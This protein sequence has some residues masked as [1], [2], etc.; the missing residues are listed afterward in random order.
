[1][2]GFIKNIIRI[3]KRSNVMSYIFE[4]IKVK[5]IE[6]KI[7]LKRTATSDGKNNLPRPNSETFSNCENEALIYADELRNIQISKAVNYLNSIKD[8]IINSTA[9]L[10]QKNFYIDNFKNRVEQTLTVANGRLSNLKNSYLT[11]DKEVNNFKLDNDLSREPKSLSLM[12]ILIGLAIIMVLFVVELQVNGNLL[13]PAMASGKKEGLAVAAAV[14]ALN[15]F[16][17][18]VVGYYALKNLH[19]VKSLR[20]II[21]KIS[22]SIY[23]IFIF[24]LNWSLG[25]Y[26]AVHEETGANL[27]DLI[28]GNADTTVISGNPSAPWT[29]DLTFTSLI[30]VFIGIGFAIASLIDGYLFDDPYPGYGNV[31]KLRNENKKEINRIR[32]H[33]PTE[34]NSIFKNEIRSTGEKRDNIIST[35]LRKDWVPNITH[36][37][38]TFEGYRRYANQL[39]E[40]I[41]HTIGEY[42]SI[43]GMY[44]SDSEPKYWKDEKGN[45]KT[46]YYELAENKKNPNSVFKDFEVLY[47]NKN[48][49][50]KQ[51]E[52][53][54]NKIQSE[55]NEYINKI[56]LYNEEINK[57][58]DSLR[59]KYEIK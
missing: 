33:L 32:E 59:E 50:E 54:Q 43:N 45:M 29:V 36:L 23:L 6:D 19:H 9:K 8:K 5:N 56:N 48:Q 2:I 20:K 13:A 38:N 47:L 31:G 26:R 28:M 10:G 25:A 27:K 52:E 7:N 39:D 21:S 51:I 44:R 37:E 15:V 16:V 12:N 3:L 1:M 18:F 24:Y 35:T 40:A 22:L 34:I 41:D 53:Y 42:R 58:I 4:N 17:S 55:S 30:L 11:H 14:A 57:K 49:I 46:R